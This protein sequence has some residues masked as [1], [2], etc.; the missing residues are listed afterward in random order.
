M[1]FN[2]QKNTCDIQRSID[3]VGDRII[4]FMTQQEMANLRDQVQD[5]RFRDHLSTHD[6]Y[7]LD[8]L[9]PTAR[10]AYPACNPYTGAWGNWGGNGNCNGG[11]FG[12]GF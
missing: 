6:A 1:N 7:L 4:N 8:Q 11:C 10:P 9:R 3:C 12:N 5:Y 2:M